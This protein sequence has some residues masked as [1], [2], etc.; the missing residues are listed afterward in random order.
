MEPELLNLDLN[1]KAKAV[2]YKLLFTL[3]VLVLVTLIGSGFGQESNG[4]ST[5][6]YTDNLQLGGFVRDALNR[7]PALLES[8]ARY[9][10]SLQ[11]VRQVT[12]LPDPMLSYSQ[13]IRSVETRV[14]PQLNTFT[15]S[16][17][18]PWFGKLDLKGQIAF[19]EA[20][21]LYQLFKARE[22]DIIADVKRAYYELSY[23]DRAVEVTNEEQSLLDHYET[24]AQARYSQGE[25]LQQGVIKIQAELSQL[26]DRLALLDRQRE[27]L[28]ARLNS[29]MDRPPQTRIPKVGILST[30]SIS[31]DLEQLYAL[32]EK[33]RQEL[34]AALSRIEKNERSIELAKKD[35][36]PDVTLSAGTANVGGRNDP[37]GVLLPPPDNGK[38][39]FSFSV[40]I[41]L[42]I[43]RD[44]YHAGVL[45]AT[46]IAIAERRNYAK[47]R[48]DME[49]SIRDQVV[50][51]ETLRDQLDLYERVLIPQAD[52]ALNSSEA[53]Y[54]TGQLGVLDLLDSERFLLRTRLIQERY[55]ADLL[56]ALAELERAIGTKFP[57]P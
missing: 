40:G 12:A 51:L 36:W 5:D 4:E 42:P 25:G 10:A 30:P 43:W 1:M 24:L 44:K 31:L 22:R 54:E 29:L 41:N 3:I 57:G 34:K 28:I 13:F 35:Y 8:L 48:N 7:N 19:K 39:A 38:N 53:A 16:Q 21:A 9:R 37:S 49:F 15:L 11:K 33:N 32:G 17:K 55:S 52:E 14:G 50:R 46:E 20:A 2:S 23:V 6:F 56:R 18:L 47:I 26:V 27:V 45:E